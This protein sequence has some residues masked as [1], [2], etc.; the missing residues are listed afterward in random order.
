MDLI[1]YNDEYVNGVYWFSFHVNFDYDE[2]ISQDIYDINTLKTTRSIFKNDFG[3]IISIETDL[4]L[5]T[6]TEI[7]LKIIKPNTKEFKWICTYDYS[8]I[9]YTIK[10]NDLDQTGRYK[11][12]PIIIY[13]DFTKSL[14]PFSFF[15]R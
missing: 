1:I 10:E 15:V 13:Q 5:N 9:Y 2:I 8:K 12:Q 14:E 7:Y 6:A 11:I 4:T 3:K